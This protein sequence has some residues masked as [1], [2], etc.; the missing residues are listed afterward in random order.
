MSIGETK[1]AIAGV[2]G[3]PTHQRPRAHI[4]R[5]EI[6]RRMASLR[7]YLQAP[8]ADPDTCHRHLKDILLRGKLILA[9]LLAF[10]AT[11]EAARAATAEVRL[12]APIQA[13]GHSVRQ[14]HDLG[15]IRVQLV[16]RV[17]SQAVEF[18]GVATAFA[19]AKP[20]DI[21]KGFADVETGLV[22]ADAREVT[23][24]N[25]LCWNPHQ[26]KY[27]SL[28]VNGD[29]QHSSPNGT[30]LRDGDLVEWVFVEDA[31]WAPSHIQ[32]EDWLKARTSG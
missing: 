22:C 26:G 9:L 24:I 7:Q 19:G 2:S 11:Q 23:C 20:V 27:W 3:N 28:R 1:T 21:L 14:G 25:G 32:L 29:E 31:F 30:I 10:L 15:Q 17:P 6:D 5:T 8:N 18:K 16:I 12:E 4:S 13:I